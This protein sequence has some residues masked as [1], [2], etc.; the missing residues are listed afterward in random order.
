MATMTMTEATDSEMMDGM[1]PEGLDDDRVIE[2]NNECGMMA[3]QSA[4]MSE[5]GFMEAM[6]EAGKTVP[7]TD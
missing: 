4:Q 1:L 7:Q 5:S 6:I 3:L 2:I